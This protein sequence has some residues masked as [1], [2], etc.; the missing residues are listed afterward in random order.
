MYKDRQDKNWVGV[1]F[2]QAHAQDWRVK[3][4]IS[5]GV[6]DLTQIATGGVTDI[7]VMF[8]NSNPNAVV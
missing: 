1:F 2:K 4:L 8:K 5:A 7:Y 3:N 6:I